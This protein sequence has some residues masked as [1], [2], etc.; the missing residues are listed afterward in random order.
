M[1][2]TRVQVGIIGCGEVAQTV[3]IP[4][5]N[6]MN[7]YFRITWL[8]D[9]SGEALE[10]CQRKVA[11][12]PPPRTTKDAFELCE[13]SDVDVVFV[14][15]LN[16]FHA[17]HTVLALDNGKTA[18][19][20]KPMALCNRDVQLILEA[21]RKSKGTVMVGYMRRYAA[22]FE[23]A[24]KELD[25]ME[26][27][28]YAR[29]RDIISRNAYFVDQSGTFPKRFTDYTPEDSQELKSRTAD[30]NQQGLEHDLGITVTEEASKMW[31]L[32][33]GLGSHDLSLMREALGMPQSV[34]GCSLN[35]NVPFWTVLFQYP[36]FVCSYESGI[37]E[38]P[39]FDAHL[40]VYSPTKQVTV[41][42]DTPYVKGLPVTMTVRENVEG[43]YNERFVRKTYEDPYTLEMKQLHQL[44]TEGKAVKTTAEDAANDLRIFQMIMEAGR[45]QFVRR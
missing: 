19:V 43:V 18:F 13:A 28:T 17:P 12:S 29:V 1:S 32:L 5:L 6:H 20:E 34:L 40:E 11:G 14:L 16:E 9:T 4:N 33:G 31:F 44:V 2:A 23:D 42:Y 45:D 25:S 15:S 39:R 21:E 7:D 27:V 3:H 8:C 41:Q 37:D 22:V 38:I 35:A 36:G 26:K 10:H 24:L 30:L